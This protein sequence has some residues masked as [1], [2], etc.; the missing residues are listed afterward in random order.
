[1]AQ[2]RMDSKS[3]NIV[4][5]IREARLARKHDIECINSSITVSQASLKNAD[6]LIK[7]LGTKVAA[8]KRVKQY[9]A[10]KREIETLEARIVKLNSEKNKTKSV[11]D[12][13]CTKK[14]ALELISKVEIELSQCSDEQDVI[15]KF[16]EKYP[17]YEFK[18][19][20]QWE[21]VGTGVNPYR[22]TINYKGTL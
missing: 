4:N 12:L 21:V 18:Y 10:V 11:I 17:Y 7:T 3:L 2:V 13:N 19:S 16:Q 14:A 20:F 9:P 22:V 15:K 1:M 5:Q 8:L 6:E